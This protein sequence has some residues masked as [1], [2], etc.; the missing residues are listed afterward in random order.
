MGKATKKPMV[1]ELITHEWLSEI[2]GVDSR[3]MMGFVYW[4]FAIVVNDNTDT[5]L[6]IHEADSDGEWACDLCSTLRARDGIGIVNWPRSK[7]QFIKLCDVL[8]VALAVVS[9]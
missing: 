5:F 4:D 9:S 3:S 8:G 6:R 2:G 7:E 1:S